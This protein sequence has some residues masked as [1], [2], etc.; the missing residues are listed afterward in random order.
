MRGGATRRGLLAGLPGLG[1]APADAKAPADM[2][3]AVHP[4]VFDP[5]DFGAAGDGVADDTAAFRAMYRAMRR[6]QSADDAASLNNV[7]RPPLE[8]VVQLAPGRYR[9]TWNRWTWGLRRVTVLGCG[10]AIQCM[11]H[12][13]YDLDQAP[14]ISN[15]DHYWTWDPEG[16]AFGPPSAPAP[17]DYGML[18][19]TAR[20]GDEAV[21][22]LSTA[23]SPG[24]APLVRAG[25]WVLL[26]SY[27]QQQ[28]GYPPNLRTFERARVLGVEGARVR[29]DRPVRH[30]HRDDWPEDPARPPAV[31]RARLVAI[32]RPD[33]P[34]ARS[35]RFFGL[36]VLPNPNHAIRDP[37]DRATRE[38]LGIAGKLQAEVRDCTLISPG[39]R[40]RGRLSWRGPSSA[41]SSRTSSWTASRSATAPSARSA[42]APG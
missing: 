15:R 41:T 21:M 22:L 1:I 25:A 39:C 3:A 23:S 2:E 17:D 37:A 5:R 18:I 33:C 16:P 24:R 12:G 7:R 14:L 32:D 10:A 29:L 42:S 13:P 6:L 11:H 19:R 26:Q 9:Y 38:I 30:L 4:Q 36:T 28:Y 35:Q 31:G 40:R 34:F 8:F 20:P 27:A